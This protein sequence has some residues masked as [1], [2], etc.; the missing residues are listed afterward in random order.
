MRNKLNKIK[1]FIDND[2][3]KLESKINSWFNKNKYIEV[4]QIL[5]SETMINPA[6]KASTDS[7]RCTISILYREIEESSSAINETVVQKK[8]LEKMDR[9]EFLNEQL[10]EIEG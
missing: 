9:L 3:T 10:Q 4:V 5:Q 1:L 2:I 6:S 8:P 7:W